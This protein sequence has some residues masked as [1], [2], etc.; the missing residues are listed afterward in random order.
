MYPVVLI[1]A[2]VMLGV[3]GQLVLK[4]GVARLGPLALGNG[5]I[6]GTVRGIVT[7]VRIWAGLGLYGISTFLWLIALSQVELGYA[8]P[9]I[10]LSYVLILIASWTLFHEE[11]SAL[12]L[13]GVIAICFGVYITAGA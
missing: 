3:V 5:Q 11:I 7:N 9:F 12:R 2:S 4:T 10:S 1:L 8:Y 6:V 13:F